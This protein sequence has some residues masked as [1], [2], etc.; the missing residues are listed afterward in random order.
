MTRHLKDSPGI[1]GPV[2]AVLAVHRQELSARAALRKK[3]RHEEL[4]ENIQRAPETQGDAAPQTKK[5][6]QQAAGQSGVLLTQQFITNAIF[7]L[8]QNKQIEG[9]K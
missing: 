4:R 2:L 1:V 3:R 6:C 8:R 9:L 5:L 7:V